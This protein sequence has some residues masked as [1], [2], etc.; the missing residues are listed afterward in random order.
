MGSA[1]RRAVER[2]PKLVLANFGAK[3]CSDSAQARISRNFLLLTSTS[4]FT[5]VIFNGLPRSLKRERKLFN[6]LTRARTL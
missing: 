3:I 2:A 5:E 1:Q 4:N 6:C